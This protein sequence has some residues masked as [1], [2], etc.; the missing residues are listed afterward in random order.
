MIVKTSPKIRRGLY[1]AVSPGLLMADVSL[2][3]SQ[4]ITFR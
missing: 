3:L 1:I 2:R 4:N